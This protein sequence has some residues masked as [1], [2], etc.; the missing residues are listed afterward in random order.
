MLIPAYFCKNLI[1]QAHTRASMGDP[2]LFRA[3][4]MRD[5][6]E[7]DIVGEPESGQWH[8]YSF[9]ISK[10]ET[11]TTLDDIVGFCKFS[12]DRPEKTIGRS[13]MELYDRSKRRL[14]LKDMLHVLS[15][16]HKNKHPAIYFKTIKGTHADRL[17]TNLT[18]AGFLTKYTIPYDFSIVFGTKMETTH[19]A[20]NHD[21]LGMF[22][23]SRKK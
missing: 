10:T 21:Q 22:L 14:F 6:L 11:P 15:I 8:E 1:N 20:M 5:F 23:E 16:I 2:Q 4:Y 13:I 19:Y 17:Y 18:K 12:I 7:Y 3:F 9:G